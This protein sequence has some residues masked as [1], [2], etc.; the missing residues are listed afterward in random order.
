MSLLPSNKFE[1]LKLLRNKLSLT[2]WTL[3]DLAHNR[4]A[5]QQ[6]LHAHPTATPHPSTL[7]TSKDA[8]FVA[9]EG[10]LHQLA[11]LLKHLTLHE[12]GGALC[13][14]KDRKK[15]KEKRTKK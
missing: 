14:K 8:H 11:D 9:V 12:E 10:R 2:S 4:V 7:L 6:T 5:A 13:G 3:R 15:K 1:P